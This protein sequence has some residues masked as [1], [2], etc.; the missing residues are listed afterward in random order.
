[1]TDRSLT[2]SLA[3]PTRS[4]NWP[5][6]ARYWNRV[7]AQFWSQSTGGSLSAHM[8]WFPLAPSIEKSARTF[9]RECRSFE[10][11][12]DALAFA[13]AA[14]N[15]LLISP[16]QDR[17]LILT[18]PLAVPRQLSRF[19]VAHASGTAHLGDWRSNPNFEAAANNARR[20][21]LLFGTTS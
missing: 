4:R 9:Y 15:Y 19:L 1:M 17:S 7:L 16:E 6:T 18:K 5:N 8:L 2:Y 10:R 3:D 21:R 12:S 11:I 14:D 20:L 13:R